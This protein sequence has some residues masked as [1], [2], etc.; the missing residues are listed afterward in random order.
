MLSVFILRVVGFVI[1][2]AVLGVA[3]M[4]WVKASRLEEEIEDEVN[5]SGEE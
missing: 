3:S 5:R 4:L 2:T 1:I